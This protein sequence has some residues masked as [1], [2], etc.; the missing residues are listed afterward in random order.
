MQLHALLHGTEYTT[1]PEA[2]ARQRTPDDKQ[3]AHEPQQSFT[4]QSDQMSHTRSKSCTR[5]CAGAS[6]EQECT[7]S[8]RHDGLTRRDL[9]A[10]GHTMSDSDLVNCEF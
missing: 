10:P 5:V 3:N 8:D 2:D 9:T 6:P 1:K 4:I 7:P